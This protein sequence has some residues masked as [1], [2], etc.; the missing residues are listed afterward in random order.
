MAG[1]VWQRRSLGSQRVGCEMQHA[2]RVQILLHHPGRV[3]RHT[4]KAVGW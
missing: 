1:S 4:L 3:E 2:V